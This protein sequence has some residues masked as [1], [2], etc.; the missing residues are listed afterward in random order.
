[1]IYTISNIPDIYRLFLDS[2]WCM[3][4]PTQKV[5]WNYLLK[6]KYSNFS[7]ISW[8]YAFGTTVALNISDLK[9]AKLFR[10]KMKV[11]R[12]KRFFDRTLILDLLFRVWNRPPGS[13]MP[14]GVRGEG[15]CGLI[16]A[17]RAKLALWR[18]EEMETPEYVRASLRDNF[19]H[20]SKTQNTNH[21]FP[22]GYI[23]C[24]CNQHFCDHTHL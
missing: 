20:A 14:L 4:F 22:P 21:S 8:S 23:L 11:Y 12:L 6:I 18:E 24:S 9:I 16:I 1:M 15:L 3:K 2:L 13:R 19:A 10:R 7:I 17:W 5:F